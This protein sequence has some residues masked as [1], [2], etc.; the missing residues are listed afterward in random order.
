[1]RET[2]DQPRDGD[3]S[4]IKSASY[5]IT[6]RDLDRIERAVMPLLI[7]FGRGEDDEERDPVPPQALVRGILRLLWGELA[8]LSDR[9]R[10]GK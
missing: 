9:V 3:R 1:M 5:D 10:G 8:A 7:L 2:K 4:H 6:W